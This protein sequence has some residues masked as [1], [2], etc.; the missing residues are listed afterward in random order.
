MRNGARKLSKAGWVL[1]R[2]W[3]GQAEGIAPTERRSRWAAVAG[4]NES[5]SLSLSVNVKKSPTRGKLSTV[6]TLAWAERV[7]LGNGEERAAEGFEKADLRIADME[8]SERISG[9]VCFRDQ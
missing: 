6:A 8:T 5:V 1:A 9:S 3:E 2:A 7:W 4:K